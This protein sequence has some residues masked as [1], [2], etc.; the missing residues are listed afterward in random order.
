[1]VVSLPVSLPVAFIYT[2]L[3]PPEDLLHSTAPPEDLLRF[4]TTGRLAVGLPVASLPVIRWLSSGSCVRWGSNYYSLMLPV[5][6]SELN[7]F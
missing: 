2:F 3:E 5:L 6:N 7:F 1:M 4:T